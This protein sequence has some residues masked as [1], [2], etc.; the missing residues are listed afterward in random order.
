MPEE[1]VIA[2]RLAK[3]GYG[4]TQQILEEFPTDHVLA[5]LEFSGF[6]GEYEE[7]MIEINRPKK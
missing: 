1:M 3:E 5:M 4:T 2:L 7:T 6:V